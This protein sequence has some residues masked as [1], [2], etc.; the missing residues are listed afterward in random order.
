MDVGLTGVS[1]KPGMLLLAS[2]SLVVDSMLPNLHEKYCTHI[3]VPITS[4]NFLSR[5]QLFIDSDVQPLP[6]GW[7]FIHT[8]D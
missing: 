2:Q 3:S 8:S 5:R 7:C 6:N 1:T 4:S